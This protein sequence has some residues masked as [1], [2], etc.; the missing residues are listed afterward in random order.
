MAKGLSKAEFISKLSEA[1]GLSKKEA[2]SY[3]EA[4]EHLVKTELKHKGEVTVPGLFRARVAVRPATAE[5]E[6]INPFTKQKILI[7]ARP[8]RRVVKAAAVKALKDSI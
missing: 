8:E 5:R 6:G 3:L 7:K 4:I 2:T 1:T